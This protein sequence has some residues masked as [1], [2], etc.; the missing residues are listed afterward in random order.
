MAFP[1]LIGRD[2]HFCAGI[3]S[4]SHVDRVGI[5]KGNSSSRYIDVVRRALRRVVG[6]G[7]VTREV[8]R[9]IVVNTASEG[10]AAQYAG[11]CS[12]VAGDGATRHGE[13]AVFIVDAAAVG[14]GRVAGDAAAGHGERGVVCDAAAK[15]GRVAA[16]GT[17]IHVEC[18]QVSDA[19]TTAKITPLGASLAGVIGDTAVPEGESAVLTD[20]DAAARHTLIVCNLAG[21]LAVVAVGD[22]QG[23]PL[24]DIDDLVGQGVLGLGP[25]NGVAVKA[26]VDIAVGF[27]QALGFG[28]L[29]IEG[30][31]VIQIIV[32]RLAG[33]AVGAGP[34]LPLYILAMGVS[35][36]AVGLAAELVL[37][38]LRQPK[39]TAD[40]HQ[41]VVCVIAKEARGGAHIGHQDGVVVG[42]LRC[43][44]HG[45]GGAHAIRGN[46]NLLAGRK[47]DVVGL[48]VGLVAHRVVFD[49]RRARHGDRAL[50]ANA[51]AVGCGRVTGDA[52]ARH[53][54]GA[55][56]VE[57]AAVLG[58]VAGDAAAGHGERAILG[59]VDTAAV[60]V[61]SR[62]VGDAAVGQVERAV[63]VDA[64]GVLGRVTGDAAAGQ[65][66][67]AVVVDTAGVAR[68]R[69]AGD[70]AAVHG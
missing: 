5:G 11:A 37:V 50:V 57:A 48:V 69:V 49:D 22:C 18:A 8:K 26:E 1:R 25:G 43:D 61:S 4:L 70:A 65:V 59:V 29:I 39:A 38:H 24:V 19:E 68:S 9:T 10:R 30:H 42:I 20:L 64:A 52:A 28:A 58:R 46:S 40:H 34:R 35:V 54:E 67:R 23:H 17:A 21:A 27:P 51:A 63:V 12:R 56:A 66:E 36:I 7:H 44:A 32:A 2:A 62:V 6:N 53:G 60:A 13:R 33:K 16:D 31:I 14:S 45:R 47:I 15:I 41:L 55:F 3:H